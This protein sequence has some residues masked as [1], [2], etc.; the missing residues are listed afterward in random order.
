M[1]RNEK[2]YKLREIGGERY[3]SLGAAQAAALEPLVQ[4]L[5]ACIEEG[6]A[7]GVLVISDG[8]VVLAEKEVEP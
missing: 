6:L 7:R 8:E 1:S 2:E 4:T 5:A 3:P